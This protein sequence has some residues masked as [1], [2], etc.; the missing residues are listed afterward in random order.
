MKHWGRFGGNPGMSTT[1]MEGENCIFQKTQY[2]IGKTTRSDVLSG[3]CG[4]DPFYSFFLHPDE[5][6]II[7]NIVLPDRELLEMI[8]GQIP[9]FK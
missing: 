6:E 7:L 2:Q 3:S 9:S 5:N 1:A 8:K 4:Q